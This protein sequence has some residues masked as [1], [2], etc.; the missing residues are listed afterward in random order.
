[1]T[2]TSGFPRASYTISGTTPS[3]IV[4]LD[5]VGLRLNDSTSEDTI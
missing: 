4:A 3:F 1:V 5:L 2:T